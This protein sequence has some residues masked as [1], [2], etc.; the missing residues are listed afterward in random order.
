MKV[1]AV[2]KPASGFSY[3]PRP[4]DVKEI[5]DEVI[6]YEGRRPQKEKKIKKV[7]EIKV[8]P[9][10]RNKKVR[11][12]YLAAVQRKKE[13]LQRNQ[14]NSVKSLNKQVDEKNK[15]IASKL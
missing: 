14:L 7:R 10:S 15:A 8:V 13:R 5:V 4:E 1:P 6:D 3:N 12:E 9:R 11:A 2:I